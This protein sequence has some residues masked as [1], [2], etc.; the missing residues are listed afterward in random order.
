LQGLDFVAETGGRIPLEKYLEATLAY[1]NQGKGPRKSLA[2]L[3]QSAQLSPRYMETL[4]STLNDT[5]SSALLDVIRDRWQKARPD[6]LAKIADEIRLWQANLTKFNSV[7][8]FKSWMEPVNLVQDSQLIR[9]KLEVPKGSPTVQVQLAGHQPK[10]GTE[11]GFIE[12]SDARLEMPGKPS[13]AIR[14]LSTG[15]E[16]LTVKA[17]ELKRSAKYLNAIEELRKV[18]D[19]VNIEVLAKE[20]GIDA[21]LLLA[22]ADYLGVGHSG[23]VSINGLFTQKMENGG[24]YRFIQSW[25]R[26]ETPSIVANSSDQQVRIPG[27]MAPHS[28]AVHPSPRENVVVGWKSPISGAIRI[29]GAVTHAHPDCGNGVAWFL[30]LRRGN[31]RRRL[32]NGEIDRGKGIV[33]T[34]IDHVQIRSGDVISLLVGPRANEHSCDLTRVEFKIREEVGSSRFWDLAQDVSGNILESNPHSDRLGNREVWNF[35]SEEIK[36]TGSSTLAVIPSGSLVDEWLNSK[37]SGRRNELA[38]QLEKLFVNGPPSKADHPD[39]VLFHQLRAFTGPILGSLDFKQLAA[40]DARKIR[41][42]FGIDRDQFGKHPEGLKVDV[43]S[44]IGG[45]DSPIEFKIP[46]EFAVG[47][48]FVVTA[49]LAKSQTILDVGQ[50]QVLVNV[51]KTKNLGLFPGLPILVSSSSDSRLKMIAAFDDFRSIFPAALCYMKIVPVDEVVTLVLFHREDEAL[52]RLMLDQK[53]HE[54]LERLWDELRY[55]SQDALRVQEAYGQFM[56]YVTQDGDVRLFEPLRKP[57]KERA[58]TLKHRLLQTEPVHLESLI[59]FARSAYRRPLT[60]DEQHALRK[61]YRDLRGKNLDHESAFRLVLARVLMSPAFL[62]HVETPAAG[63]DPKPINDWELACRLS[64]F[65]WSSMPDLEL[66]TI[67]DQGKLHEPEVLKT[68]VSRMLLDFRVQSLATE[69]ACQWI[70][71][72]EFNLHN[73]KSETIFPQFGKLRVS[74]YEE[75][76]RFFVHLFQRNASILDVLDADYT[77][78][79]EDL[80]KHYGLADV[81][82]DD[83]RRVEGIKK[84]G[85]GGVLGMATLLSKQSGASRT[86]PILRGNWLLETLLG[87]KLPKPPKNVPQLP[88]SELDTKG[89]TMRQVTERHRADPLCAKCHDKIDPLGSA[90]EAYDAIGRLRNRDLGGR[91]VDTRVE[92]KDGTK[93]EGMEGLRKYVLSSRRDEFLNVFCRKLLGYSLG[94]SVL[95]SDDPLIKQMRKTLE[96]DGQHVQTAIQ[97]IVNSPQF[98]LRR[99]M[100]SRLDQDHSTN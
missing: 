95:L 20:R 70:D 4:W 72:R 31:A 5:K 67:A 55:I 2:E 6:D 60:S 61:L 1:R 32:A 68:Q 76:I 43:N 94:R 83:W 65:L 81:T 42:D 74:M 66:S 62:F 100:D 24:G 56:E 40:S 30:E 27:T 47:R 85:R 45:I 91:P 34:P 92:L 54:K 35:Y 90:L 39:S 41:S 44:V 93:F 59:K 37:D 52:T 75:S 82:G 21:A 58:E 46:S 79:N 80:A 96:S 7:S 89:L 99:G 69:F 15:I 14:D 38:L 73:E 50:A 13:I 84:S 18:N 25:G 77:F 28:I 16:A 26:P 8:H 19:K 51:A 3:A 11:T 87:E 98:R 29:E 36:A 49:K 9:V 63:A 97:I 10:N 22:W 12:W 23:S 71:I 17:K 78:V 57:I 64:Y 33:L 48:E 88:E 86:S 53:E